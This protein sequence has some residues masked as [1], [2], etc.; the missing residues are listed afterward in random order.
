[1]TSSITLLER[2]GHALMTASAWPGRVSSWL[3]LPIILAV[4]VA[5]AGTMMRMGE[6]FG[7]GFSIPLF[8]THLTISGLAELQWHLFAVIVMLGGTYT[9]AEDRHVRVDFIYAKFGS[10]GK[11]MV[12]IFG[13]LA[14]LLPFC[15]IVGWLSLRFVD[16]AYRSG[17]QSDYGG[18]TDRYLVKAILPIGMA[19]LF[20]A[21]LGRVIANIGLL[22][23]GR[24]D[25]PPVVH[26]SPVVNPYEAPHG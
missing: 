18:L 10:R 3:I 20:A 2:I 16:L 4:L 9:F 14:L 7:W 15:A 1:M 21:G 23:S 11:A 8:G 22:L 19:F 13:D 6:L 17:E 26:I 12:N 24:P 25:E 5:V